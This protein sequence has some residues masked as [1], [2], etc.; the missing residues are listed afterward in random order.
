MAVCVNSRQDVRSY[1]QTILLSYFL[2]RVGAF[3]HTEI[4]FVL[5]VLVRY[6]HGERSTALAHL[7]RTLRCLF[8]FVC[9]RAFLQLF[10]LKRCFRSHICASLSHAV[11]AHIAHIAHI[12]Q[13]S[14]LHTCLSLTKCFLLH[15][16]FSHRFRVV[17]SF[18]RCF[19]CITQS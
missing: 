10:S 2:P 7:G 16:V 5:R 19:R 13:A 6:M 15:D 11:F 17:F 3:R 8:M 4:T 9:A 1:Y 14:L 18:T 12:A